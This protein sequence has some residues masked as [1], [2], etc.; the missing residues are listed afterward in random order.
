[1]RGR[2]LFRD[3]AKA[4]WV[5]RYIGVFLLL[6]ASLPAFAQTGTGAGPAD[7]ADQDI[8]PLPAIPADYAW[9]APPDVE[10]APQDTIRAMVDRVLAVYAGRLGLEQPPAV[11][12]AGVQEWATYVNY[13][14]FVPLTAEGLPEDH[15]YNFNY[16]EDAEPKSL[17]VAEITETG[18]FVLWWQVLS[19]YGVP[20]NLYDRFIANVVSHELRH[21]RQWQRLAQDALREAG[22]PAGSPPRIRSDLSEEAFS[23]FMQKWGDIAH[24][25]GRELD[26]YAAQIRAQELP[27]M[28]LL[29]PHIRSY[30]EGV[31][32]SPWREEFIEAISFVE[33]MSENPADPVE[34]P[35]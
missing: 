33:E 24:Y 20:R 4:G 19:Y 13:H 16:Y 31:R 9:T 10:D 29:A 17:P 8:V 12:L 34:V 26:V 18:E 27:P 22:Q 15:G 21:Y 23:R 35:E 28:L 25:Q 3:R 14:H 30:Y 11:R 6:L 2:R 1:M 32:R 5:S 7:I